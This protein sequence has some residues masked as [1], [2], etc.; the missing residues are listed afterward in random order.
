MLSVFTDGGSRGNPGPSAIGVY[1][2]QDTTVLA[3]FGK[4]IGITTNNVAEY[5]AVVEALSWLSTHLSQIAGETRVNFFMDSQLL[6]YQLNGI[7][8]IKNANLR[9]LL[10]AIREKE[11]ALKLTI[12]YTHVPREKNKQ[13]DLLVNAAL[14][15]TS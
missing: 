11:A 3:A 6:V 9:T 14:D 2:A 13:A 4:T 7:Y 12:T 15:K 5:T 8:R 10:F 1:I